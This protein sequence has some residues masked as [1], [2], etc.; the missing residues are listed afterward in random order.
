MKQQIVYWDIG[1]DRVKKKVKIKQ[2]V[3]NT[4]LSFIMKKILWSLP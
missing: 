4:A 3:K 2:H 1:K